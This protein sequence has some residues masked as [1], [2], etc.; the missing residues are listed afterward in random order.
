MISNRQGSAEK[1]VGQGKLPNNSDA[2]GQEALT[3]ET[4]EVFSRL[5][6]QPK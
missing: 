3:A 4:S 1:E 2:D 5:R 6:G